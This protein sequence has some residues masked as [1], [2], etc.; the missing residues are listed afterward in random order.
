[1]SVDN[2]DYETGLVV[3]GSGA[4]GMTAAVTAATE[5]LETLVLEKTGFYGGTT[6]LSAGVVWAPNNS[7]MKR[8]RSILRRSRFSRSG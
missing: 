4:A 5:G 7:L 6:A 3:V 8:P 2:W 1:M